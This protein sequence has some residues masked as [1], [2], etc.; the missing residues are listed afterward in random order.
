[1]VDDNTSNEPHSTDTAPETD[2]ASLINNEDAEE[3]KLLD[4]QKLTKGRI[5]ALART[6]SG[7]KGHPRSHPERPNNRFF[8]TAFAQYHETCKHH[9]SLRKVLSSSLSAT[10]AAEFFYYF[11]QILEVFE[12]FQKAEGTQK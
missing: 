3:L 4:I 12:E 10:T 2:H 5:A 11:D 9:D 6:T 8:S 1:M 7:Q